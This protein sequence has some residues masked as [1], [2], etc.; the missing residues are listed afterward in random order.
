M[1]SGDSHPWDEVDDDGTMS[2]A[3]SSFAAATHVP[4]GRASSPGSA[5]V[6]AV[7]RVNGDGGGGDGGASAGAGGGGDG[8]GGQ[9]SETN[10]Q[11]QH[12]VRQGAC[13]SAR[14]Y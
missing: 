11:L 5:M 3:A 8:G 9:G 14:T 7:S 12:K 10:A 2:C 4:A 6:S 13:E 1:E